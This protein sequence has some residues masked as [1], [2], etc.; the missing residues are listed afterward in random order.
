M[1]IVLIHDLTHHFPLW[2]H[3]RALLNDFAANDIPEDIRI[4]LDEFIHRIKVHPINYGSFN[5]DF[6][7]HFHRNQ[8]SNT[9]TSVCIKSMEALV[10]P[11]VQPLGKYTKYPK[12]N[13]WF[14]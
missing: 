11:H 14:L 3:R 1:V 8:I 4:S 5:I 2:S 6:C 13:C 7:N 9:A 10:Q 12:W